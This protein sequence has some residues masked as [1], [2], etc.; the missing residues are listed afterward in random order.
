[1]PARPPSDSTRA[2]T[3]APPHS[4]SNFCSTAFAS[5][6]E[7]SALSVFALLLAFRIV[8]ALTL[9]TFFQPDEYFQSLE[10]AWQ[11]AFGA[12][13]HAWI[14]WVNTSSLCILSSH[15]GIGH[16]LSLTTS[17]L[18]SV[19]RYAQEWRSQ[20]RSCLHPALFAAVYQATA[21]LSELC[22][23]TVSAEATL[24][25][26]APKIAQAVFAAL[27]DLYTWK[28]SEKVYGQR[29]SIAFTTVGTIISRPC[30]LRSRF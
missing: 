12:D 28:L 7:S 30:S 20:L 21:K 13:S 23:L 18:G 5:Y 2:T 11:L 27:L 8:N 1:M 19:S 16:G 9:R 15:I 22:A 3:P 26:A 10:P 17:M 4:R 25:I 6:R 29:S 24:F 14:T